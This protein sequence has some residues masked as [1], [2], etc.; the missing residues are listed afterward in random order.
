VI[1]R[2]DI[3]SP[4]PKG[5]HRRPYIRRQYIAQSWRVSSLRLCH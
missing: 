5:I 2:P 3:R 4:I 1:E